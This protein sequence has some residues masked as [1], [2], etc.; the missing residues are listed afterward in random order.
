MGAL[1]SVGAGISTAAYA[2]GAAGV[3]GVAGLS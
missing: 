1:L 2:A 3:A